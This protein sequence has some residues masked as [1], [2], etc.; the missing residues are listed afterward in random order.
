MKHGEK[1]MA[2]AERTESAVNITLVLTMEEAVTLCSLMDYI[3]GSP[4]KTKRRTTDDIK[5]ALEGANVSSRSDIF[6]GSVKAVV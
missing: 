2:K 3:G 5:T 1:M 6:N 4:T